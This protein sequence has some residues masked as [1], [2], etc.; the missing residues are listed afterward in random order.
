MPRASL[1]RSSLSDL[2]QASFGLALIPKAHSL[3]L[4][5]AWELAI[6]A[7]LVFLPPLSKKLG[8]A[9]IVACL[10]LIAIG[11]VVARAGAF[12]GAAALYPCLGAAL[13]IWP[14]Q[15][16]TAPDRWLGA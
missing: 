15:A 14:R 10:T 2:A 8:T 12:P 7:L 1:V 11:F 4:P 16:E 3:A 13:V 9:A 5:R 6:G